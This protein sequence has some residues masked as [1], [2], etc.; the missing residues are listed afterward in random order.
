MC[1]PFLV[2]DYK[3]SHKI[4][5]I[6]TGKVKL[7]F[8]PL[9]N[10][11][12]QVDWSLLCE[13]EE[14]H[15]LGSAYKIPSRRPTFHGLTPAPQSVMLTCLKLCLVRATIYTLCSLPFPTKS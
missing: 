1:F 10:K 2:V 5:H 6:Q 3:C 14:D 7:G 9:S 12:I 4:I 15:I 8:L 13:H 11:Q